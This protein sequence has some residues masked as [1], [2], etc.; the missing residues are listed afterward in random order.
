MEAE[1]FIASQCTQLGIVDHETIALASPTRGQAETVLLGLER[2]GSD[3]D[4]A[5]S[6]LIF[7]IDTI[8][9]H[10]VFPEFADAAD[11]YLEVF[12]GEGDGWSFVL[13]A[14]TF[15]H[16]VALTTE[17]KRVSRYC[18]TGL[19]HFARAS[20]FMAACR[21]A[22]ENI[23]TYRMHWGEIYIAPLYNMLITAGRTVVYHETA[24]RDV[25]LSGT[26][27]QYAALLRLDRPFF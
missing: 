21:K 5:E 27:D 12:Q 2:L 1:A 11:G 14:A 6:L 20:E 7:N 17:K 13:P 4:S 9:P 24:L 23:D 15:G 25:H 16:R 22:L 19:Y 3:V 18:C 10:Y 26:P 8:R